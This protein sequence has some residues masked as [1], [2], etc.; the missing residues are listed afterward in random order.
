MAKSE[1]I[2]GATP[3]GGDYSEIRYFND[4]MEPVD[5]SEAKFCGIFEYKNDGTLVQ[6]TYGT[7]K[8]NKE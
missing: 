1:R 5:E 2:N 3:N 8:K 7:V 6:R 4:Q